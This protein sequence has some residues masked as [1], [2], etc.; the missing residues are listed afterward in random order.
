MVAVPAAVPVDM[1][2]SRDNRR[3]VDFCNPDMQQ[4]V[5]RV[6]QTVAASGIV[7]GQDSSS[8]TEKV[9]RVVGT[10]A[11]RVVLGVARPLL[12][13]VHRLVD[14]CSVSLQLARFP[15]LQSGCGLRRMVL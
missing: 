4:A 6:Q 5:P 14:D 1:Q 7:P 9:R 13:Q 8:R 2:E 15:G 3:L 11:F 10:R 12:K